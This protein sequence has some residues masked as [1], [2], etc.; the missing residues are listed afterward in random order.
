MTVTVDP[1]SLDLAFQRLEHATGFDVRALIEERDALAEKNEG[2]SC[3]VNR[4]EGELQDAIAEG[5]S[6]RSALRLIRSRYFPVGDEKRVGWAT[7]TF[8]IARDALH[9]YC[10]DECE[11]APG[12]EG[13]CGTF[14]GSGHL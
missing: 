6:Y 11:N 4:I 7:E 10:S 12:H 3:E 14:G 5:E 13:P 2:W 1:I 9:P 8:R